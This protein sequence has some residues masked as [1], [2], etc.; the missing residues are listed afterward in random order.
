MDSIVSP[1]ATLQNDH[2]YDP[3][4]F[5]KQ[6]KVWYRLAYSVMALVNLQPSAQRQMTA[7]DGSTKPR[8]NA[9]RP[10]PDRCERSSYS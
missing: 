7:V 5:R 2:F 4:F 3:Y 8:A 9:Q 1:S 10:T 6:K